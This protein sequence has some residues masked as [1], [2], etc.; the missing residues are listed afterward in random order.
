[1]AAVAGEPRVVAAAGTPIR[2]EIAAAQKTAVAPVV[3]TVVATAAIAD[4]MATVGD[5]KG[6]ATAGRSG[7]RGRVTSSPSVLGARVLAR[8][9]HVIIGRGGAGDGAVDVKRRSRRGSPAV[10]GKGNRQ[11]QS[12]GRGR[13]RGWRANRQAGRVIYS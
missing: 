2:V 4:L 5:A 13:S 11:V 1:M 9:E 12:D 7:R 3:P 6:G 8:G 10:R